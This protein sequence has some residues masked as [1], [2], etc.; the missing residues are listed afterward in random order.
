[1]KINLSGIISN[2]LHRRSRTDGID[3]NIV[4][5]MFKAYRLASM[6]G[7]LNPGVP[8]SDKLFL[9]ISFRYYSR[10]LQAARKKDF[11]AAYS[12]GCPVEI[13]YAMDI[14]PFQLEATGWLLA[15]LTGHSSQLLSAAGESGLASEICSVH[16]LMV[17]AFARGLLPRANAV[18][19]TNMPC[20]KVPKRRLAG[21]V[22]SLPRFL[23]GSSL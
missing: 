22:E 19:W 4:E 10:V 2:T 23:S 17:G 13:L 15:R 7:S 16:R 3:L 8:G 12:L 1:M 14:V 21:R 11:V 9:K 6:I 5:S 20:E 18:L